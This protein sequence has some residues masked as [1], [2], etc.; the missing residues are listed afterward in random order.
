MITRASE[1]CV[2]VGE[3]SAIRRCVEYSSGKDRK[4]WLKLL[5][6][7]VEGER[8]VVESGLKRADSIIEDGFE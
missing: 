3:N 7:T 5:C 4:T 2:V 1:H 6:E 8:L